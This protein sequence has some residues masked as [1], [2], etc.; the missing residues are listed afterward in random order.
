MSPSPCSVF[1][2]G[3]GLTVLLGGLLTTAGLMAMTIFIAAMDGGIESPVLVLGTVAPL[4]ALVLISAPAAAIVF[5]GQIVGYLILLFGFTGGEGLQ[6]IRAVTLVSATGL[7]W[8]LADQLWRD[9]AGL[10]AELERSER[11]DPLTGVANRRAF[12]EALRGVNDS[13]TRSEDA[14]SVVVLEID[15]FA[16]LGE[17]YGKRAA[18]RCMMDIAQ[19][20]TDCMRRETDTVARLASGEFGVVLG[21]TNVFNAENLVTRALQ[22]LR[23]VK[24]PH[25][26]SRHGFVTLSA[27][28]SL[29]DE[30]DL[31]SSVA[32]A[33][34]A[35]TEAKLAGGD[36]AVSAEGSN[37]LAF[38]K[39][40]DED[41]DRD[42]RQ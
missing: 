42:I 11:T 10:S 8:I 21:A 31:D 3:H 12:F 18:E 29:V 35:L 7:A 2:V 36:R 22:L 19:F 24:I 14:V 38:R 1:R 23:E 41:A 6:W 40:R 9:S 17:R 16:E 26:G 32:R 13:P 27:G 15:W 25:E 4:M 20:L 33:R 30:N 5:L 28:V 34:K 39:P 37:S